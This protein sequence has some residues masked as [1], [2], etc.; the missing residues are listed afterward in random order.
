MLIGV[1]VG[2]LDRMAAARLYAGNPRGFLL[3]W[4]PGIGLLQVGG[5]LVDAVGSA[6]AGVVIAVLIMRFQSSGRV[7]RREARAAQA[8]YAADIPRLSARRSEP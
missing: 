2:W 7:H 6:S 5:S 1:L 4:L 8:A 3:W